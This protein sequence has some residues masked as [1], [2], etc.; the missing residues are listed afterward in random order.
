MVDTVTNKEI[1]QRTKLILSS[2]KYSTSL[3]ELFYSAK[4]H[5][6]VAFNGIKSKLMT[7]VRSRVLL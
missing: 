1:P 4:N 2:K 5:T 6:R 3:K 7:E